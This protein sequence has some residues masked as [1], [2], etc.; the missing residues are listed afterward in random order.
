MGPA[1]SSLPS[2]ADQVLHRQQVHAAGSIL[3]IRAS[4]AGGVAT[5][6]G[7]G[8]A[9]QTADL[10]GADDRQL[11]RQLRRYLYGDTG[12]LRPFATIA[13]ADLARV[14]ELAERAIVSDDAAGPTPAGRTPAGRSPV[15]PEVPVS[16]GL[17]RREQSVLEALADTSSRKAIADSLFISVNT[18]KS[19]LASIYKKLASTSRE[20]T[21]AKARQ[22][23]LLPARTGVN[24]KPSGSVQSNG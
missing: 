5:R 11:L 13:G 15:H 2:V 23:A 4:A 3:T 17:S 1:R 19:H 6:P 10:H 21:L 16:A 12:I 20:E 14:L 9:L 22:R 18:V 7:S 8:E 24:P